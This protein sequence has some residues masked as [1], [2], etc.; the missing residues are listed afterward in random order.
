MEWIGLDL[1]STYIKCVLI[2]P[3]GSQS[4]QM[5]APPNTSA[6][7][8]RYEVDA[9]A[10]CAVAEKL[11]NEHVPANCAGILISTQMHGYV[12]SD[13]TFKAISPYVS[14][15]DDA[16][17][18]HMESFRSRYG[19][20]ACKKSGVSLKHN[21]AMCSLLARLEEGETIPDGSLFHTL[22]G[23]FIAGLTGRHACHM[24]NA[25]PTGL[26]DVREGQWNRDLL[27]ET[28]LD[29]LTFPEIFNQIIPVGR[30]RGIPVYPD[31][32]DQQVCAYGAELTAYESLHISIGT[33][34]LIGALS[35]SWREGPWENRPW[36][37]DGLYLRSVSALPGGRDYAALHGFLERLISAA[38]GRKIDPGLIWEWMSQIPVSDEGVNPA[39]SGNFD[40]RSHSPEQAVL[41]VY[42]QMAIKYKSAAEKLELPISRIAFSGGAAAKSDALRKMIAR[43]FSGTCDQNTYPIDR[44][45]R[46]L[47]KDLETGGTKK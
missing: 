3:N 5:E 2:A 41:G 9:A 26:A 23:Y 37:T 29:V 4:A 40:F 18:P 30:W 19:E 8:S 11:L 15:Q 32:G 1:G 31:L 21:L 39:S 44:G 47:C 36:L 20:N 46:R 27:R 7:S 14:W 43:Q 24:T 22:G 35:G 17:I 16:A 25:A 38:S 28:K 42:E 33:A 6:I 13:E 10:Y 12:L 34:G 45:L